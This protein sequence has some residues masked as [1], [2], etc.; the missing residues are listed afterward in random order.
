MST[1]DERLKSVMRNPEISTGARLLWWELNQWITSDLG[2][3]Y[4]TQ[5]QLAEDLGVHRNTVIRWLQELR[6]L[7]LVTGRRGAC[8]TVL[9][10]VNE[11]DAPAVL[12]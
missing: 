3:C 6:S 10:L 1:A 4:R 11:P 12:S 2:A 5:A 8:G 9:T 7:G